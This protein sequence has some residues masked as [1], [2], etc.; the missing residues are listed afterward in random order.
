MG[1]FIE[2]DDN[3]VRDWNEWVESR[4]ATV[5][6]IAKRFDP[7]SLYWMRSTGQRVTLYSIN[8][9]GTVSVNVLRMWNFVVQERRVFGVDPDDLEACD[10]T[11]PFELLKVISESYE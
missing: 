1:R 6:A 2:P 3:N 4:P 11:A 10:N 5:K 7:W 9:N 8:E